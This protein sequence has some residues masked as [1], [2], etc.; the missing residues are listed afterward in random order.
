[1]LKISKSNESPRFRS[2]N[3]ISSNSHHLTCWLNRTKSGLSV[4]ITFSSFAIETNKMRCIVV[5][6]CSIF[7][8]FWLHLHTCVCL[9]TTETRIYC[10]FFLMHVHCCLNILTWTL[11]QNSSNLAL[12]IVQ[13]C[14]SA[15]VTSCVHS[16]HNEMCKW[17]CELMAT[18]LCNAACQNQFTISSR[19]CT[20]FFVGSHGRFIINLRFVNRCYSMFNRRSICIYGWANKHRHKERERERESGA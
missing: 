20:H 6:G 3:G 12:D 10:E 17:E 13:K 9:L 1:M 2:Y 16:R 15:S 19:A 5:A 14:A 11:F 4:K 18:K 7:M 8:F